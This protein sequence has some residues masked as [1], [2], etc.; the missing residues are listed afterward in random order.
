MALITMMEA[1]DQIFLGTTQQFI[2][3]RFEVETSW[4]KYIF[5]PF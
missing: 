3:K 2:A 4:I 1:K 5:Q